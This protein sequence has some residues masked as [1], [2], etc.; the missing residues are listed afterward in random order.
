MACRLGLAVIHTIAMERMLN[1]IGSCGEWL[2][3]RLNTLV[4]KHGVVAVRGAGLMWGI[5]LDRPAAPVVT[6]LFDRG[7]LVGSARDRV[8]RLLPPYI[9]PMRALRE[10]RAALETTLKETTP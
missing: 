10:F 8:V 6:A 5:E 1:R 3:E 4:G 9:V 2:E 7:F